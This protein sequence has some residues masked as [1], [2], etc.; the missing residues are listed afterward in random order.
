MN[1]Q[2]ENMGHILHKLIHRFDLE[3][4]SGVRASYSKILKVLEL[5]LQ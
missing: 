4:I 5:Q 1:L 3:T 2:Y